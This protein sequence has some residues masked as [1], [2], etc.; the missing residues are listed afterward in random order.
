MSSNKSYE[1]PIKKLLILLLLLIVSPVVLSLAFKAAK[2]Y[3][4]MP[5]LIIY[6]LLLFFG[7]IGILYSV[8]FGFRT[9]QSFLKVLFEE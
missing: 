4:E 1:T 7:V 2:I 9:I 6:Y 3:T 8:Y 5:E